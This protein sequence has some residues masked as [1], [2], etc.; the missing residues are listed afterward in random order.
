MPPRK[1]PGISTFEADLERLT[2]IVDRLESGNIPLEEMLKLYEEG[3]TLSKSLSGV[4]AEAELRVEKLRAVHEEH[5]SPIVEPD[6]I[7]DEDN[8][9]LF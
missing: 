9:L 4:L 6:V 8:D 2:L 5:V 7:S 3:V 1:T